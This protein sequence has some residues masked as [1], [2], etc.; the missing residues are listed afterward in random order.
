M[1]AGLRHAGL[2]WSVRPPPCARGHFTDVWAPEITLQRTSPSPSSGDSPR[3]PLGRTVGG[4]RGRAPK[5]FRAVARPRTPG[6]ASQDGALS[7]AR[8][9]AS[10][11][12]LAVP[13]LPLRR[14]LRGLLA[15]GSERAVCVGGGGGRS[16]RMLGSRRRCLCEGRALSLQRS[17]R[18]RSSCQ[19]GPC[20]Q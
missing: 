20:E 13:A 3:R 9:T 10:A 1:A 12:P 7:P 6:G 16:S 14:P 18:R 15:L 4:R 8:P 19:R 17:R 11:R 5:G 2:P